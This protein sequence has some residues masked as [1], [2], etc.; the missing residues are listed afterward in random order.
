MGVTI[1]T[2][3]KSIDMGCGSF[4]RLRTDIA[5]AINF[6]WGMKYEELLNRNRYDELNDITAEYLADGKISK[7]LVDFCLQSDAEGHI[8]CWACKYIYRQIQNVD[9]EDRYGLGRTSVSWEEIKNAFKD[10]SENKG[11]MK[12]H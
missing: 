10:G 2:K 3:N 6:E 12:W 11:G 4:F 5:K 9:K 8:T 1:R 7:Y